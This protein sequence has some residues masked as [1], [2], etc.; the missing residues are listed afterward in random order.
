ME[1]QE[2]C[3]HISR[4]T[5]FTS[6]VTHLMRRTNERTEFENIIKILDEKQLMGSTTD[7]GFIVGDRT[8]LCFQDVILLSIAENFSYEQ[9]L[10]EKSVKIRYEIWSEL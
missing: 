2:L 8:A 10:T 6:R 4:R 5:D 7:T 1:Y 3:E 9:E